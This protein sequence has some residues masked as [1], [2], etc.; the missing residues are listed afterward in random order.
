M[1]IRKILYGPHLISDSL[2]NILSFLKIVNGVEPSKVEFAWPSP[3]SLFEEPWKKYPG[4]GG[5]SMNNVITSEHISSFTGDEI[6]SIY[7]VDQDN[8]SNT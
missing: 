7:E 2:Q 4:L 5:I 6:L 8:Q 1:A 3:E